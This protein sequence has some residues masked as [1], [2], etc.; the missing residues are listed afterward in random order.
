[1]LGRAESARSA[2]NS[3]AVLPVAAKCSLFW[4]GVGSGSVIHIDTGRALEPCRLAH[5]C[6]QGSGWEALKKG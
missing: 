3:A 2:I 5:F 1:M 4:I 6:R